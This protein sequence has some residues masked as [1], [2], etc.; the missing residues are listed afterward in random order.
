MTE[1]WYLKIDGIDGESTAVGHQGEIDVLSWSWGVSVDAG[2]QGS[3]GGAGRPEFGE[4]RVTAR[5]SQASPKLLAACATGRHLASA[6]LSGVRPHTGRRSGDYLQ[7]RLEEVTVS[8]VDHRDAEAEVPT[9]QFALL[10]GLIEVSYTPQDE[11]GGPGEPVV[12]SY[13]LRRRRVE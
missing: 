1:A 9:E 13:D 7:Y 4:L 12:F 5:I 3:G 2:R 10:Y 8:S 11:T 6:Q